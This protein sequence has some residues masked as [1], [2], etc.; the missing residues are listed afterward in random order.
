MSGG[1]TIYYH[2]KKTREKILKLIKE[3]GKVCW[4]ES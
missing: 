4:K 2:N 3:L 1:I